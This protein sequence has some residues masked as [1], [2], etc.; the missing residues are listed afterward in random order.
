MCANPENSGVEYVTINGVVHPKNGWCRA[1][2]PKDHPKLE[3]TL[4]IGSGR[5]G[6]VL[7]KGH[8]GPHISG[9]CKWL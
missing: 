2:V 3:Q 4:T 1:L 5:P 8:D 6:C 9:E 7:P